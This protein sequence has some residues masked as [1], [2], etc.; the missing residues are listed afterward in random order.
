MF[1]KYETSEKNNYGRDILGG[2][3]KILVSNAEKYRL[4]KYYIN[5]AKFI[6]NIKLYF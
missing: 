1:Y 4:F 2:T 6:F 5:L 3:Y